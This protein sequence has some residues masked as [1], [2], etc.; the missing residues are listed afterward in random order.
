MNWIIKKQTIQMQFFYSFMYISSFYIFNFS[1]LFF[2]SGLQVIKIMAFRNVSAMIGN[3]IFNIKIFSD[4]E[5]IVLD[6]IFRSETFCFKLKISLLMDLISSS[7][8][9]I[10]DLISL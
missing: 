6:S 9:L 3:S 1:L 8:F 10:L 2:N 4:N 5:L 7:S